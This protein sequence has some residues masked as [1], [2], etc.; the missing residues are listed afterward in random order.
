MKQKPLKGL[1]KNEFVEWFNHY[2]NLETTL[3]QMRTTYLDSCKENKKK[4]NWDDWKEY[5][6]YC[7]DSITDDE[8]I[9]EYFFQEV[10]GD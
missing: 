9:T 5:V 8:N 7:L 10:I 1:P 2:I 4:P 6:I 3:D